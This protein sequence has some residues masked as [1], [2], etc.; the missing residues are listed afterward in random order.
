MKTIIKTNK[1]TSFNSIQHKSLP[2]S[3]N[4]SQVVKNI[5]VSKATVIINHNLHHKTT[6]PS[7]KFW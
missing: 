3:T 1:L 6:K 7:R 2:K 4:Q 5:T